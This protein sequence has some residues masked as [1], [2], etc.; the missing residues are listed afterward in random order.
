VTI[1]IEVEKAGFQIA[2]FFISKHLGLN[3]AQPL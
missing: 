1:I 2:G 3:Y